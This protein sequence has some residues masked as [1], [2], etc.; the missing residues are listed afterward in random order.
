MPPVMGV[1]AF[2]F[3]ALTVVPYSEVIIAALIPALAYF[4]CLSLSVVFQARKQNITPIG[5]LTEEMHLTRQ[6][7]LNLFMI[8]GQFC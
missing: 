6:D 3:S 1:A 7:I 8:L 2:V 5:E 4:L